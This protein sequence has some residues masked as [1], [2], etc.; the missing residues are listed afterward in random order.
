MYIYIYV[1][2]LVVCHTLRNITP[3]ACHNLLEAFV[4]LKEHTVPDTA[5]LH[6]SSYLEAL[7]RLIDPGPPAPAGG[8][9]D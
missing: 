2:T 4:Y 5:G 8:R 9:R 6:I 3:Q 7:S 1:F